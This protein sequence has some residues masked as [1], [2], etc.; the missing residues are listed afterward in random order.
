MMM[1]MMQQYQ[2]FLGL[3][4]AV[5]AACKQKAHASNSQLHPSRGEDTSLEDYTGKQHSHAGLDPM[6]SCSLHNMIIMNVI[7]WRT[8]E[9]NCLSMDHKLL[10]TLT[11]F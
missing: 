1:M 7:T 4:P 3:V 5:A 10:Q 11:L 9:S 6:Q 8:F 2:P